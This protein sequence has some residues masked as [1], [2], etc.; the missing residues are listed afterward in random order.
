M[1]E[2]APEDYE[3]CR[4]KV[5]VT[6]SPF[7]VS[8]RFAPR[9]LAGQLLALRTF[10]SI[11]RSIPSEVSEPS[12]G[13]VKLSWWHRE[14][15]GG[16]LQATQHPAV[17]A[18]RDSSVMETMDEETLER[19]FA[20]LADFTRNNILEDESAL[21]FLAEYIGGCEARLEVGCG[22]DSK[23][24]AAVS[25]LGAGSFLRRGI[26][27]MQSREVSNSWWVPLNL[28]ARHG[29]SA[30]SADHPKAEEGWNDLLDSLTKLAMDCLETG[31]QE[32]GKTANVR[33][34]HL[35]I[36]A[37]LEHRYLNRLLGRPQRIIR[38]PGAVLMLGDV[39]AAWKTA[40]KLRNAST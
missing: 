10:F 27:E 38:E 5:L 39:L 28:Q 13:L 36:H 24:C 29:V 20:S 30:Q 17:R 4:Q 21:L 34:H 23:D 6:D 9:D 35:L 7:L 2:I 15:Q 11:V 40:K 1:P 8:H 25:K 12:V 32:L 37:K 3:F 19:Y 33:S 14:L 22:L 16:A 31:L 26:R 18:M